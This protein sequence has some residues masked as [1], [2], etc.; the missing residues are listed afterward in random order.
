MLLELRSIEKLKF[1]WILELVDV[2]V[3]LI[4]ILEDVR[5]ELNVVWSIRKALR[6]VESHVFDGSLHQELGQILF[7]QL[8]I[9]LRL[10]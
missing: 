3:V 10:L 5:G 6:L 9:F 8:E 1:L 4:D 7:L 2:V